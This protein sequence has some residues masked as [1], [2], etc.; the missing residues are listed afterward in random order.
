M[1]KIIRELTT[2]QK[3]NESIS[4][5]VMCWAKNVQVQRAQ[6]ALLEAAKKAKVLTLYRELI[7]KVLTQTAQKETERYH[8]TT[9]DTVVL[10]TIHK[11]AQHMERGVEDVT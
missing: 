6:R 8:K 1:N 3:T 2:I 9:A 10:F 4:E 11:D 5:K 7:N